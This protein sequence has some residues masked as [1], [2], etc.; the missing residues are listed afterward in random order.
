MLR[1]QQRIFMGNVKLVKVN[2]M[3]EHIDTAKVVCSQID[4]LTIEALTDIL[5]AKNFRRFQKQRTRTTSRVIHLV[6][7]CF[8]GNRNSGQQFRHFLR[9]KELTAAFSG[10]VSRRFVS[11]T[12]KIVYILKKLYRTGAVSYEEFFR[13][14]DRSEL[15]ATFLAMLEL[16]KSRR[17]T[18]SDDNRTVYFCRKQSGGNEEEGRT[19]A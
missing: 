8:S 7:L 12:T 18:V 2:V 15:V 4:F 9:C 16:M 13:A 17:I 5:F 10:I 1:I 14:S 19:G 3:Q 11:V 6:D